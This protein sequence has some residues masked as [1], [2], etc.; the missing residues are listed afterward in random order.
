MRS[1]HLVPGLPQQHLF[2]LVCCFRADC[3]HPVCKSQCQEFLKETTWYSQGPKVGII[4][5]LVP[6]PS[7]DHLEAETVK[8]AMGSAWATI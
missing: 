2:H 8:V 3:L 1:Y 6:D 4:P 7:R 5:L